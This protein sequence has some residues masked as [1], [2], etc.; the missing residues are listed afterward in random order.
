MQ[1]TS[2][3]WPP[4]R[5]LW[6]ML[7]V[8][9]VARLLTLGLYPIMDQTEAR[10]A[11]IGRKML[12]LGDWVTP[13][14]DYGE[15]FWG[16]P[17]F[18]FWITATSFKF[19]GVNAFAARLPH[20][21]CGVLVAWLTWDWIARRS[22]REAI[23]A[24]ALL[25]GSALFIVSTGAVMTDMS[26]ALGTTLAMRG[27]WLGLHGAE[28]GRRREQ[29]LFFVGVAIGLLAKGPIAAVLV[30]FPMVVWSLVSGG[31]MRVLREF[32]W[33][34]GVSLT[35]LLVVPWYIWAELRSP[36]FIEYFLIG[37]HWHRFVTP[38]WQGD[39]YGSAHAFPRGSIWLFAVVAFLPWSLIVPA[40]M[41]HW[42]RMLNGA[43][44][45]D[46]SLRVYLLLWALFPC[47]FF[48]MAG[49]IL[50]TYVLPG[51]PAF[52]ILGAFWLTRVPERLPV[53]R[54]LAAGMSVTLVLM[55]V[56][57]TI[58]GFGQI[59]H[60][61][62]TEALI[63]DYQEYRTEGEGLVFLGGRP[64]SAAFYSGGL[65]DEARDFQ[66]L[67]ARIEQGSVFVVMDP[68]DVKHLPAA[69]QRR[70]ISVSVRGGDELL[71]V[72]PESEETPAAG[73]SDAVSNPMGQ[74]T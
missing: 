27:F 31:L 34:S 9:L 26:L 4:G 2:N 47:V 64:Y 36:G 45:D 12:E 73:A 69:L 53:D 13:W 63:A 29:Y 3:R 35:L 51:I 16:K 66:Q 49:N 18:S 40:T 7:G 14:I 17:P 32:R 44:S 24:L 60:K 8:A 5:L 68:D 58:I 56:A 71:R 33:I 11:E 52:A 20:L 21:I 57:V 37:E 43:V 38:G 1:T 41:W 55:A 19:F 62:S 25:S 10:Y 72:L 22:Q 59:A 54:V 15:P 28:A 30:G 67:L 70:L 39:L 65:A 48:S 46:G 42:R 6:L 50:W 61:K 74:G 23:Y